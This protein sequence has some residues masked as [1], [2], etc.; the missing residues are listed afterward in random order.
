MD[1]GL[2]QKVAVVTGGGNGIGKEI[3]ILLAKEG[4]NVAVADIDITSAKAVSNYILNMGNKATAIK[5]DVSNLNNVIE[6]VKKIIKKYSKIDILIN[7]AGISPK[8]NGYAVTTWE[9]DNKEWDIVMGVNLKG[10]LYCCQEVIKQMIQ[11]K[12]GKIINI[13]SIAGKA[14]CEPLLSSAHYTVSK[15]GVINLTQK[16]A[17]ESAQYGIRVNAV[18][19][20][21]I[22]TPLLSTGAKKMIEVMLERTP[23]GRSGKPEEIAQLVLFLASDVSSYITGE[24]VNINGGWLMD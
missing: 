18:A 21:V 6:L 14:P 2:Q 3:C 10:V 8:K 5:C 1:L 24:T 11:Q 17:A 16:L 23:L 22:D 4:A 19:P 20:G 9:I 15:A 7:N 12:Q 13:A